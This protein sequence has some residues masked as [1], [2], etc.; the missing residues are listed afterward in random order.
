MWILG[1]RHIPITVQG[2]KEG[3]YLELA[4]VYLEIIHSKV[5]DKD[6]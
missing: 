2:Q 4:N 5:T 6:F 1:T 3:G